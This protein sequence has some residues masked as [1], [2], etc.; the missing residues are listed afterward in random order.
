MAAARARTGPG[1]G[2]VGKRVNS[3]STA[4][5][6]RQ[7]L[8][9]ADEERAAAVGR[10]AAVAEGD[11]ALAGERVADVLGRSEHRAAQRVIAERRLVDQ[12]LGHHRRL[13]VGA[14]DLLHD[15]AALA[16][17]LVAIDPRAADEVGEQVGG[18]AAPC[19][20]GR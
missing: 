19:W 6:S 16:I 5:F 8:E 17:E 13:V 14:R 1:S 3:S 20:R 2:W 10:P 15:H 18:L 12:V 7:P 4:P 11:D 9:V